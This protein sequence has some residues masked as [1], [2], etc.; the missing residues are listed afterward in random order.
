NNTA[1]ITVPVIRGI[2]MS[3]DIEL[4]KLLA[5]FLLAARLQEGV[6]QAICE[7]ADCGTSA[8]FVTIFNTIYENNLIRFAAV[9]RAVA[10]WTGICDLDNVD[11]I[12]GKVLELIHTALNDCEQAL[13][14]TKS[15]DSIE[16]MC[17]LWALGFRNVQD[18]LSVMDGYVMQ[19]TRNQRLTMGYYN[20]MLQ[21]R[22]YANATAM[23][24][25]RTFSEDYELIAVFMPSFLSKA[26]IYADRAVERSQRRWA[27]KRY[28]KIPVTH[29]YRD[30]EEA[31]ACYDIMKNI[32]SH[33]PKKT[34]EYS[35]VVFPWYS[36]LI[37]KSQLITRMCVTAYA[38]EDDKLV[39]EVCGMLPFIDGDGYYARWLYLEL[40]LHDPKTPVQRKALICAVAD[41]ESDTRQT[42]FELVRQL[43][44]T[45]EDFRELE[46]FL[47]Y[48]SA[49]IRKSVLQ[50]LRM[51]D[52]TAQLESAKRLL[53]GDKE[54][55]RMGGLSMLQE[56]SKEFKEKADADNQAESGGSMAF[57]PEF[58]AAF[59]EMITSLSQREGFSESEQIVVK[60]LQ[61]EGRA[62]EVLNEEGYGLFDPNQII[63]MPKRELKPEVFRS[64][65]ETS[66]KKLDAAFAALEQFLE[67]HGELEYRTFYGETELLA[68]GL[69]TINRDDDLPLADRY[70]F[71]EL[72]IEFY[73]KHIREPKMVR[74]MQIALMNTESQKLVN[75]GQ[76]NRYMETLLGKTFST[77]TPVLGADK[78]PQES[79]RHRSKIS[80]IV[81]ILASLYPEKDSRQAGVQVLNYIAYQIPGDALWY[82]VDKRGK[83]LRWY[84]G[85]DE[86][87]LLS[88][89]RMTN[90]CG[91][92]GWKG[93]EAFKER[94]SVL[95]DIDRKLNANQH[96]AE[97]RSLYASPQN[98]NFLSIFDY[99]QAFLYGM[100]P[101]NEI[102]KAAFCYFSL[103]YTLDSMSILMRENLF[104]YQ[105]KK[106][107]PYM[108]NGV[109]NRESDFYKKS[110]EVYRRIMDKVLDVEL[111]RGD[112][113]TVFSA[114]VVKAKYCFGADR[115]VEILVALGNEKL[116]RS[117]Y[118][119]YGDS[120]TSKK[121]V[122]S[123]LLQCCYPEPEDDAERLSGLLEKTK[124][125]EVR[126]YETMMYAPQW[127]D[128]IQEYLGQ[129][130]KSGCYY[131]MAHMNE[132][133]DDKKK[134]VIA[135]YT[136]LSPEELNNGA[137]DVQW[138]SK[139]Y[140][141]LGA[142]VFDKLYDAAKYISDGSKHSRARKYADAALGRVEVAGLES[143]IKD[144]RN[145]DLLMSYGIVPIK[146]E[147][148][149]LHRY[150]FIEQFR[151]ESRQF[152][153]QRKASEGLACDMAMKN[154]ATNAGY[155]DVT[156]LVLAME[157]RMVEAYQEL[158]SEHAIGEV[159]LKLQV[160]AYGKVE[161]VC[162]KNGKTL[163]SVPAALKK[164]EYVLRLKEV[165]KKLKEQYRRTVKMFEQ[166][167]EEREIYQLGELISL[168]KNP[169]IAPVVRSLVYITD[170]ALEDSQQAGLIGMLS[171][172]GLADDTGRVTTLSGDTR[173][174][175]AH[176]FDL[177]EAGCWTDYQKYIFDGIQA[178]SLSR[179][180]F[181]QVFR[182][183]YVKLPE[184]MEQYS[185]RMFAGNQIQ[186]KRT[187]GA[188]KSRRWLA[189]SEEGLQ[190]IYYKEN[191]I[192]RIYALAD[193]FSPSDIEAPTLEWV[194]FSDRNTFQAIPIKDVP[195]V[196]Y[197]EV[198]R[199]VDLAVS[200][201]HVGGVDPETSHSTIEM[202][203]VIVGFNLPL[204]KL[205]NVTLSG[206]HAI[207]EGKLGKYS[208]HLGSGVVHL[209][210]G[211]KLNVLPVHS[212]SRG[213][214]F[215]PFVDED[216]KTAEIMSK[217]V[218]FAK[219]EK[220]KDPYILEQLR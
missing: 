214:I 21:Y 50:L 106:L 84:S 201:A 48:K 143:Q 162:S 86:V 188:L 123:H 213:K 14:Y 116:E 20:T 110:V 101:E 137:F 191:I 54:E 77:Y 205:T 152:G 103:E 202:R 193:W 178:G 185:S 15:N 187:V 171:E 115:L 150:E 78:T 126:L 24:V 119:Y 90:V 189:D 186:P 46:G 53:A 105:R 82:Q 194:E 173:V 70:P 91:L 107:E 130:L 181:K 80:T 131:F 114:S 35:P 148:D 75:Q 195:D 81:N 13:E 55:L 104:P 109:I 112:L 39:D 9:K 66:V 93:E 22:D 144:K 45:E 96:N 62:S 26:S 38:L 170:A 61:G 10:T 32:Y 140:E 108:E 157:S 220:I 166:A 94:F 164:D 76:Y 79:Y 159:V 111:G 18:A 208:I 25:V 175:V 165:Q 215:L 11:R 71:K 163:K 41:R 207:V 197:S 172:D 100:I 3:S 121:T 209:M 33:I 34:L 167:M 1:L 149:T 51:Q 52:K 200:V 134:A 8:A 168:A 218:L 219:D 29:L 124:I 190:K 179:Q 142:A 64:Y 128:I 6:R 147:T 196:V 122:L 83:D 199:D 151:K 184:E 176:P 42:A 156:R 44:L 5:D 158:F 65:F 19:G 183:L 113:P 49:D 136:P 57:T 138:F 204:F 135:K 60:E 28:Y 69:T 40:L 132:S 56:L 30:A 102:Y 174:R 95:Y 210:G 92:G 37:S 141:E 206:S 58:C 98:Y 117:I 43:T 160:D 169:V 85:D 72:W 161:L 16:I 47:R 180:P 97:K 145:K 27:K 67:A 146:D 127:I 7:N 59:D 125:K 23:K 211:P 88:N 216:P 99:V 87:S 129:K 120:K 36:A 118:Y 198:M 17:G 63:S 217:I 139:A 73:E 154:L 212:Q 203:S 2:V 155:Q 192:A 31:Y 89:P 12:S 177:Y 4:H 68:N 153:A 133:F 182:E 74:H